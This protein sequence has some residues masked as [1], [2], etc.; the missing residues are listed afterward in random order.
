MRVEIKLKIS[1]IP[2]NSEGD[3]SS[4]HGVVDD[5]GEEDEI[6]PTEAIGRA[7]ANALTGTAWVRILPSVAY[8]IHHLSGC[9]DHRTV[10]ESEY[11]IVDAAMKLIEHWDTRDK[12]I[13][14]IAD[15]IERRR[16]QWALYERH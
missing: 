4:Y 5:A 7:I 3:M 15:E 2:G 14:K 10:D 1:G 6:C 16:K 8:A 11:E 12:E 13:Q 9:G